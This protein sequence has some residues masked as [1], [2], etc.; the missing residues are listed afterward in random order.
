VVVID[1]STGGVLAMVNQPAFNPNDRRRSAVPITNRAATDLFEPAE[2]QAVH[3]GGG[4]ASGRYNADSIIDTG[5]G[6]RRWFKISR[7]NR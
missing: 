7:T 6:F 2:H 4:M 5:A 3:S 1:V